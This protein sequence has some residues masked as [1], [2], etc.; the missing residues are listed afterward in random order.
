MKELNLESDLKL[1]IQKLTKEI[2]F[3][4]SFNQHL[5]KILLDYLT[6]RTKLIDLKKRN[7]LIN[8]ALVNELFLSD[9]KEEI[10]HIIQL[11]KNGGNL[12]YFL[13]KR[14]LQANFHDHLQNEWNI[15]H[16]HLSLKKDKKT[17]FVKQVN[18]L[19]FAYIDDNQI[20]FL[21]TDIHKEG[22]FG[23]IKWI[24]ILHDN[25]PEVIKPFI[26]K[27]GITDVFPKVNSIERQQLWNNG[28]TL[29]FTKIKDT[30]YNNPGIGRM[31]SGHGWAV[32]STA[33][34]ILRWIYRIKDQLIESEVELCQYLKIDSKDAEFKIRVNEKLE[35]YEKVSD[36]KILTFPE[37]FL[38][39]KDII[40]SINKSQPTTA[41]KH[42]H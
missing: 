10:R 20:I 41:V 12:N 18:Q 3:K 13:S 15:F 32:S 4:I 35:L 6:V 28:Y 33:M 2:G 23:D 31:T 19:L 8:P 7:V 17:D 14:A 21:G 40:S 24:E 38:E 25:F 27:S 29:G 26:T 36:L 42:N 1:E 30:I 11:S 39:K 16:F 22:V 37:I 34:D 9:K 5:E